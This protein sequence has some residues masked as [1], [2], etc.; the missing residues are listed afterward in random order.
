MRG[1]RH[2]EAMRYRGNAPSFVDI[3]T[4]TDFR[5]ELI[6]YFPE[7][8]SVAMMQIMPGEKP[9]PEKMRCV[10]GLTVKVDGC[11]PE[12]VRVWREAC[13][14]AKAARVISNVFVRHEVYGDRPR[15]EGILVTDTAEVLTWQKC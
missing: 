11:D 6:D 12:T 9:T 15:F 2:L 5:M 8:S 13:I 10:V 14:A 3:E 1:Q 4:D 7:F